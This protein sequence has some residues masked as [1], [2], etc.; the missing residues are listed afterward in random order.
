MLERNLANTMHKNGCAQAFTALR[1]KIS[2]AI[3]F[4]M[5]EKISNVDFGRNSGI[6]VREGKNCKMSNK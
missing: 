2:S 1:S 6:E 5:I 4:R 3:A